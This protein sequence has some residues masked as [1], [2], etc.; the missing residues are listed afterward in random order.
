MGIV[1]SKHNVSTLEDVL[2][3]EPL[4]QK[5]IE[6]V[7]TCWNA[8][9]NKEQVGISIMIRIFQEH[10]EIKS[11]WIFATNLETEAEMLSNSQLR[12][13]AKKIMDVIGKIVT[14]LISC[15]DIDKFSVDEFELTRLGRNHFHYGVRRENFFVCKCFFF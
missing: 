7:K 6:A 11:K 8:I 9:K 4:N 10:S 15:S 14:K 5:E 1:N 3:L 12:Y 13:H 2:N